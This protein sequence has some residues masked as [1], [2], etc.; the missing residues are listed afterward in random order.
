VVA[1]GVWTTTS[2]A[3]APVAAGISCVGVQIF[4]G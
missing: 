1:G 4:L 3:W 2:P